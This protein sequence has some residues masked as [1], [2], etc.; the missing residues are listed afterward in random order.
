MLGEIYPA[1]GTPD[2]CTKNHPALPFLSVSKHVPVNM[3]SQK[4]VNTVMYYSEVTSKPKEHVKYLK[5]SPTTDLDR[6][7][8]LQDVEVPRI[9]RQGAH[10][11]GKGCWPCALATFIP[12]PTQQVMTSIYH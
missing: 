9:Y 11:G 2:F 10:E 8:R 7:L 12:P 6:T 4:N 1:V 5:T 3:L